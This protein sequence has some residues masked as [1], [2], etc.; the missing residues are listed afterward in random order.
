MNDVDESEQ[1]REGFLHAPDEYDYYR[2]DR[3]PECGADVGIIA[4]AWWCDTGHMGTVD[5]DTLDVSGHADW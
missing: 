1:R 2:E 3:C 5:G 4:P